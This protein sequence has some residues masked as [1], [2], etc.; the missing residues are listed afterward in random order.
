MEEYIPKTI[1]KITL[2]GDI[3]D[4]VPL[5]PGTRQG[6]CCPSQFSAGHNK[7]FQVFKRKEMQLSESDTSKVVGR[8]WRRRL[9]AHFKITPLEVQCRGQEVVVAP[10][11][12]F[13]AIAFY[14]YR[15]VTRHHT[16]APQTPFPP[17]F[18]PSPGAGKR[19]LLYLRL[20]NL[21]RV[22][23]VDRSQAASR[24]LATKESEKCSFR[25]QT[26]PGRGRVDGI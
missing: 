15:L 24:T 9:G 12:T 17:C 14:P 2:N 8:A 16:L 26:Y 22:N 11:A 1:S 13:I 25:F 7:S 5:I 6:H 20:P 3:L 10:A 18:P 21:L 4:I 19:P 23:R